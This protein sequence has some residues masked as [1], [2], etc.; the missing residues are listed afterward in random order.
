MSHYIPGI[1]QSLDSQ[2]PAFPS[3]IQIAKIDTT[4]FTATSYWCKTVCNPTGRTKIGSDILREALKTVKVKSLCTPWRYMGSGGITPLIL[5]LGTRRSDLS[6]SWPGC[7]T[8][9]GKGPSYHLKK[10]LA[11]T[12]GWLRHYRELNHGSSVVHPTLAPIV[13]SRL[14]RRWIQKLWSFIVW[15]RTVR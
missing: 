11:G 10:T 2:S 3:W 12:H 5:N 1:W 8:P 4:D 14:S 7:C 6:P 13:V 15:P 9:R